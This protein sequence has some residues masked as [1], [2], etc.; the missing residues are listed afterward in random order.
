MSR[1]EI[2]PGFGHYADVLDRI[3]EFRGCGKWVRF[4]C[5]FPDRHRNGDKNWSGLAWIGHA[6]EL[7]ARCMGCGA[8]WK[9]L[10][11]EVGLPATAWFPNKGQRP[12]WSRDHFQCRRKPVSEIVA[13]Y[14]YRDESGNFLFQ[15]VRY[16]PKRFVQRRPVPM[17]VRKQLGISEATQA[18]VWGLGE[19]EYGRTA[20]DRDVDLHPVAGHHQMSVKLPAVR[21][22]LYRL[23]ELLSA[24]P[25]APVCFVEGEKDVETLRDAGFV[26][27]CTP[28]SGRAF[29]PNLLE[30][31]ATRRV[32]VIADNDA[33]GRYHAASTAGW[34]LAIGVRSVRF[35][36]PGECG[37]DVPAAGD[38]TDWLHERSQ[39][40]VSKW[41]GLFIDLVKKTHEYKA[42]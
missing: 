5:L 24:N 34:L 1:R 40:D 18:W 11:A 37:Y 3:G 32:V 39:G 17:N 38:I 22:V 21:Y 26:A 20:S 7:T 4:R 36:N 12:G 9:E 29:D 6:G 19:G 8:T 23:P 14:D 2:P 30:P 27:T 13:T 42:W 25:E 41:R 35:L 31:L 16:E 15:K 10:V 28:N 33:H